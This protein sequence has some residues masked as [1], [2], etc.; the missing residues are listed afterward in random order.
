MSEGMLTQE[1]TARLTTMSPRT[2]EKLRT[3]GR[4]PRY[5]KIGRR[6]LYD[7][8]DVAEWLERNKVANTAEADTRRDAPPNRPTPKTD[9]QPRPAVVQGMAGSGDKLEPLT[10]SMTPTSC[11]LCGGGLESQD[12]VYTCTNDELLCTWAVRVKGAN[13][14]A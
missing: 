13:N 2:F 5:V 10:I 9:V 14:A 4:G 12:G 1:G 3:T 11:G 7:P 8:R 6:V